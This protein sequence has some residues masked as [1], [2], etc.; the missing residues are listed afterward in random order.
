VCSSDLYSFTDNL[1]KTAADVSGDTKINPV[2]AL[3]LNRRY[4]GLITKYKV[5]DWL[6]DNLTVKV[7]GS[8][9]IHNIKA[10]CAG[11]VNGSY[12]PK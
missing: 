8:D 9:V 2:D 12:V 7:N 5:S 3:Y 1:L 10:V 6:F 11:D 4:I